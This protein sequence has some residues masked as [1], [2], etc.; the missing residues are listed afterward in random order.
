MSEHPQIVN[1]GVEVVIDA[2]V[3]RRF[4]AALE[5]VPG[6]V[7]R[8]AAEAP[9]I[10]HGS[11]RQLLRLLSRPL[12]QGSPEATADELIAGV[13]HNDG[14]DVVPLVLA[15]SLPRS[16]RLAFEE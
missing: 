6:V 7:V 5:R 8:T 11:Q 13:A 12:V 10:R 16:L 2:G 15:S 4:V 9:Y 3:P 1:N 14:E